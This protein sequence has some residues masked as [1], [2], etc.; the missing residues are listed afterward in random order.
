MPATLAP[1][2]R[3]PRATRRNGFLPPLVDG[4]H[5]T[6]EDF[7]RRYEAMPG[8]KKAELINGVVHMTPP[9]HDDH[10]TP[11]SFASGWITLYSAHTPGTQPHLERSVQFIGHSEVQPD[12]MLVIRPDHGGATFINERGN[13]AGSPELILEVAA[14]SANYDLY[15][16]K[17]LYHANRVREYIVWQT[18]DQRLDWFEWEST[19]YVRRTPDK[20]GIIRSVVFPGLWLNVTALLEERYDAVLRTVQ[21]GLASAEHR[22]FARKLASARR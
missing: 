7:E 4:D 17:D 9:V 3:A 13:L 18:L 6:V 11:H 19:A 5:L 14:T 8:L 1:P 15:E 12:V 2:F 20:Q 10:S 16:K 21:A 22:G